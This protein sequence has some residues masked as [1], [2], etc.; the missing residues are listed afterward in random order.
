MM[1]NAVD[2]R[3]AFQRLYQL[4]QTEQVY[5]CASQYD[6]YKLVWVLKDGTRH[7]LR[8]QEQVVNALHNPPTGQ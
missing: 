5:I 3:A 1:L 8:S 7:T 4:S 2:A 6:K